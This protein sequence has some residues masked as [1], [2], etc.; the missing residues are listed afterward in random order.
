LKSCTKRRFPNKLIG[1]KLS[2]GKLEVFS[3]KELLPVQ[4]C[5]AELLPQTKLTVINVKNKQGNTTVQSLVTLLK[6]KPLVETIDLEHKT[7]PPT[8]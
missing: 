1:V 8:K 3:V 7:L 6:I 5:D 4:N 2:K